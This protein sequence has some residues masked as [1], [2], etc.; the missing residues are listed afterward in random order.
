MLSHRG[1]EQVLLTIAKE[2]LHRLPEKFEV[3]IEITNYDDGNSW[4]MYMNIRTVTTVILR[5]KPDEFVSVPE[6]YF[7]RNTVKEVVHT[8]AAAL[9]DKKNAAS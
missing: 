9:E 7:V 3:D 4:C 5:I 6:D 2:V 8:V 1:Q